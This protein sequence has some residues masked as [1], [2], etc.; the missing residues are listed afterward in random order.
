[1]RGPIALGDYRP[2]GSDIDL[3]AVAGGRPDVEV[4]RRVRGE[5][6]ARQAKPFFDGLYVTWDDLR[7]DPGPARPWCWRGGD[8]GQPV[9]AGVG[10]SVRPW[11]DGR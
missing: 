2:G 4:L 3:V 1:M 6:K 5:L 10:L 8:V 11:R 9:A 7:H